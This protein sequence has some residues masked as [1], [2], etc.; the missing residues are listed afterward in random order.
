MF[1]YTLRSAWKTQG[2]IARTKVSMASIKALRERTGAPIKSVKEALEAT[3]G[4]SELAMDHL[5]KLG[6]TLASKRAHRVADDG[7]IA[8]ALS[9]NQRHGAIIELS[10]ETDFVAR[11]PQFA[12]VAADLARYALQIPSSSMSVKS[13]A[14]ALIIDDILKI[15]GA[16]RK[17]YDAATALGE[18]IV[19]RRATTISSTTGAISGYVHRSV[20]TADCGKIGVLVA[21]GCNTAH[22]QR[23]HIDAI[24]RR[25]AM[26]VA[27]AVPKY[28]FVD[29]IPQE[30]IDKERTIL[31][32]TVRM[33]GEKTGK[34]KPDT[35]VERIVDG[36]LK[37]W[38][39]EVVLDSQEMLV[40][41]DGYSGKARSVA[42]S[43]AAESANCHIVDFTRF[44]VGNQ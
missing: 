44:E 41:M 25:V 27:A 26:H 10:S 2:P 4:D 33:E 39:S 16:E 23:Q 17:I 11:T 6:A 14:R 29:S 5:R 20:G 8:I 1:R 18:N 31:L 22:D 9:S 19:L 24:G 3:E 34:P 32:E 30:D 28:M 15:E 36:K 42:G 7:L 43:V 35:V 38:V 37:K 21:M 13:E 12:S 40:E